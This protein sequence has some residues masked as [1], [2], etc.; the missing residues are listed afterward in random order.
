M[1]INSIDRG[2]S[3]CDFVI[4]EIEKDN[5]II[6]EM[7]SIYSRRWTDI[8]DS[9]NKIINKSENDYTVFTGSIAG[10]P[11]D[12]KKK[13]YY[14]S[15]IDAIGS[16]AYYLTGQDPCLIL[17]IGT[18]STVVYFKA[19]SSKHVAGTG[20]GGGTIKGLCKLTIGISDID[21]IEKYA[22]I[23][24]KNKLNLRLSDL[25]YNSIGM[26]GI[27]A[28]ASN[29]G[30][31]RSYKPEDISA[32]IHCFVGETTGIIASLCARENNYI[33]DIVVTG[34]VSRNKFIQKTLRTVAE[35]YGTN[36]LHPEHAGY[37]TAIGAIKYFLKNKIQGNL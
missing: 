4:A 22:L 32:A 28:T 18:G 7:F 14:V 31:I 16:G 35:I 5:I 1:I 26:I 24:D 33:N 37:S 34:K 10:I 2:S 11:A 36:F 25:G 6:K 23:G 15:E 17:N 12:L 27:D 29:F 13:I 9:Y 21:V 3:C 20:I 8:L 19:G 30:K